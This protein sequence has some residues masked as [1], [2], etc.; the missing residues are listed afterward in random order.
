[1]SMNDRKIE[2]RDIEAYAQACWD[3]LLELGIQ[4]G[5]CKMFDPMT[6]EGNTAH[7]YVFDLEDG[8]RHHRFSNLEELRK[9]ILTE[10]ISSIA[11]KMK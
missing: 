7:S 5:H 1:M 6:I 11:E 3:I 8:G 2:A 9:N 10:T 4:D